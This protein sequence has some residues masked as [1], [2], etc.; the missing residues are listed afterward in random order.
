[1]TAHVRIEIFVGKLQANE[2]AKVIMDAAHTGIAGDGLV[3][4]LPVT[5]VFHIRTKERF[6]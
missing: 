2:I 5:D 6:Q 4:I 3:A 1:M